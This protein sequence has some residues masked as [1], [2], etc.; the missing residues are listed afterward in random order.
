MCVNDNLSWRKYL[1]DISKNTV[2]KA[3]LSFSLKGAIFYYD[4][5]SFFLYVIKLNKFSDKLLFLF[6]LFRQKI[7][8]SNDQSKKRKKLNMLLCK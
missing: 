3:I 8:L 2:L 5:F 1:F 7:T 6:F 4:L